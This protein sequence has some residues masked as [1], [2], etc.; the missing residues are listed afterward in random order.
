M[1]LAQTNQVIDRSQTIKSK[2]P[3]LDALVEVLDPPK[4]PAPPAS[5]TP[6]IDAWLARKP[7]APVLPPNTMTMTAFNKFTPAQKMAYC[8]RGGKLVN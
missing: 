5:K 4:K 2:R 8:K 1:S 7:A 6:G 3:I